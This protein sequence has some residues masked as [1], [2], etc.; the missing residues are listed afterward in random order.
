MILPLYGSSLTRKEVNVNTRLKSRLPAPPAHAEHSNGNMLIPDVLDPQAFESGAKRGHQQSRSNIW[1]K[2][3]GSVVESEAPREMLRLIKLDGRA[4]SLPY[5][6][7]LY[8][9]LPDRNRLWIEMRNEDTI[10]INGRDLHLALNGLETRYLSVLC[11]SYPGEC[12]IGEPWV[13]SITSSVFSTPAQKPPPAR[14]AASLGGG[15]ISYRQSSFAG[16]EFAS[17]E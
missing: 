1:S 17:S 8:V 6:D 14:T 10:D 2:L 16:D 5:A 4:V 3:Q 11:E 13:E 7:L 12:A 9:K 15:P